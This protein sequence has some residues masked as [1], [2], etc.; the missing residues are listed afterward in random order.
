MALKLD[1]LTLDELRP[2]LVAA[3][4]PHVAFDGWTEAALNRAAQD[5][6]IAEDRA[7]LAF[8]RGGL[9]MILAWLALIDDAMAKALAQ[10]PL[11]TLKIRDRIH[12]AVMLRLEQ[13]APYKEAMRR[14]MPL[15][16]L[17]HNA[18]AAL[19]STWRTVDAMWMA[20][21]D[22]AT[23]FN[24]YSKRTLL[25]GIYGATL[26]VWLDD[27]SEG[28]KETEGFLARRIGN[29][30]AFEKVKARVRSQQERMPS[31][32]RFLGRLR[33]PVA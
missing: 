13:I 12:K 1:D 3:L 24:Y 20:A 5:I 32:A 18:S 26:M 15:L 29:V 25:A 6:G 8:P 7:V 30:M 16:A 9:D 28:C 21:G 2:H 14:A 31:V 11:E 4:L 23:D 19:R 17:P 22:S 33:Y 10:Y 27:E